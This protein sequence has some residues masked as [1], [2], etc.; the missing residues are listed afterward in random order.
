MRA[1][2][3][4][5]PK[6]S[7]AC[8]AISVVIALVLWLIPSNQGRAITGGCVGLFLLVTGVVLSLNPVN[9]Y[10]RWLCYLIPAGVL[11]EAAGFS[12][13]VWFREASTDAGFRWHGAASNGFFV[14][15]PLV[16]ACFVAADCWTRR[17]SAH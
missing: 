15:W 1:G 2:R 12:F 13:D 3:A 14:A 7:V 16:I 11:I 10:R 9:F 8:G 5:W 4:S 6:F 17:P